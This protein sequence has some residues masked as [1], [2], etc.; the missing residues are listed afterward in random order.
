MFY[1]IYIFTTAY[2]HTFARA[3]LYVSISHLFICLM[4][5]SGLNMIHSPR[6]RCRKTTNALVMSGIRLV[7]FWI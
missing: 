7:T 5:L 1:N 3:N 2:P 6:L 4:S